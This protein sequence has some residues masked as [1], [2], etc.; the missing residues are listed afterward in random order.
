[1]ENTIRIRTQNARGELVMQLTE[2]VK[3]ARESSTNVCADQLLRGLLDVAQGLTA[4][5]QLVARVEEKSC[6]FDFTMYA[7]EVSPGIWFDPGVVSWLPE[8][9][10]GGYD[11]NFS[12]SL[13]VFLLDRRARQISA[14]LEGVVADV[15]AGG[16]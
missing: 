16:E 13:Q 14:I 9:F 3:A 10:I 7:E 2:T 5:A 15:A 8:T 1:M 11:Q 6:Q 12:E 4:D